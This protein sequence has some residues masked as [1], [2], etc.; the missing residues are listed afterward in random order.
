MGGR[1]AV[2]RA[3]DDERERCV[4]ALRRAYADGRLDAAELEERVGFAWRARTR[5]ELSALLTDL[6]RI[7]RV[8]ASA[9]A[10]RVPSWVRALDRVDRMVLRGHATVFGTVN[11]SFVGIWAAAGADGAFWPAWV[12]VPWAP[13][14]AWHFAGSWGVR[15][16]VRGAARRLRVGPG[17]PNVGSTGL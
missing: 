17:T 8:A 5:G 4:E 9:P 16:L 13:A 14:L 15:R 2:I 11:G 6:P 10:A 12:L 3:S 1:S 7:A